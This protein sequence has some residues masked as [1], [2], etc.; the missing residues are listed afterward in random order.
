[1]TR[2]A[3]AVGLAASPAGLTFDHPLPP[4]RPCHPPLP[5]PWDGCLAAPGGPFVSTW[6]AVRGLQGVTPDRRQHP[7]MLRQHLSTT[8][9][10][11]AVRLWKVRPGR[12]APGAKGHRPLL[13][14]FMG[15]ESVVILLNLPRQHPVRTFLGCNLSFAPP[16]GPGPRP[17][18]SLPQPTASLLP[19]PLA[20]E[21]QGSS[22]LDPKGPEDDSSA[23]DE[24][25]DAQAFNHALERLKAGMPLDVVPT[26]A[27]TGDGDRDRLVGTD[28]TLRPLEGVRA[29][30]LTLE[31]LHGFPLRGRLLGKAVGR[32]RPVLHGGQGLPFV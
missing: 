6:V 11:T 14:Q 8:G 29:V 27:L 21:P 23:S 30:L 17:P 4:D 24:D 9:A 2:W 15:Q 26:P 10:L 19:P 25:P 16:W 7:Q 31:S 22:D 1:M 12:A 18:D 28:L 20:D 13:L 3:D 5:D 32:Q